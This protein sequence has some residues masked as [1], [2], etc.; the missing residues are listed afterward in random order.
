MLTAMAVCV[1]GSAL[2]AGELY[3]LLRLRA[4]VFVVEQDCPYLDPDGR[5]LD[6]TTRHCWVPGDDGPLAALRLLDQ[7]DVVRVGRVVTAPAAR[8]RG[9]AARLLRHALVEVG[10]DRPTVMDAQSHLVA[11]YGRFG[12]EPDGPQFVEDGIPHTPLRR[13]A[14]PLPGAAAA[15]RG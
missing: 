5:D 7:G 9:L 3:D 10:P 2:T 13:A 12:Y 4:A 11:W 15:P 8:G 14:G 1:A 6:A